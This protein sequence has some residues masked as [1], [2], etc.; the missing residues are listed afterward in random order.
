M[1]ASIHITSKATEV[2]AG[3]VW[4]D[5]DGITHGAL[6]LGDTWIAF[7]DPAQAHEFATKA[8]E[9]AEA[10]ERQAASNEQ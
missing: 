10:I 3:H 1:S 4:T 5:N 2:T 6:D 9:L 7:D 8:A